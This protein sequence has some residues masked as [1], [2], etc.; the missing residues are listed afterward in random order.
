M[1]STNPAQTPA[2]PATT[3][4]K[5]AEKDKSKGSALEPFLYELRDNYISNPIL[6]NID[7]FKA[8]E[9]KVRIESQWIAAEPLDDTYIKTSSYSSFNLTTNTFTNENGFGIEHDTVML[10][11]YSPSGCMKAVVRMTT[12]GAIIELYQFGI[13]KIRKPVPPT[14]HLTPVRSPVLMT[15]GIIW[16]QDESRFMYMADD[17]IPLISVFKLKE[18]GLTR[19]KYR[20]SLGDKLSSHSNPTI[21][22]FDLDGMEVIRVHKP[23]E[24]AQKRIIYMQPAFADESGKSII[25]CSMN[26]VEVSDQSYFFNSPKDLQLI[27]ELEKDKAIA[28]PLGGKLWIVKPDPLTREGVK[29]EVAFFPK[30]SPDFKRISYMYCEKNPVA[31]LNSCGLRVLEI[32]GR[33][34]ET[35]VLD[36]SEDGPEFAGIN[37]GHTSLAKYNWIDNERVLFSSGHHQAMHVFEV[38][39]TDK[40]V[41]RTSTKT[42]YSPS[43]STYFL[44]TIAPGVF[45]GKRDTLYRNG[46]LY[47]AKRQED[48]SYEEY[49]LPNNGIESEGNYFEEQLVCDGIEATFYGKKS[50]SP[51]ETKPMILY[52]HGGPHNIWPNVFNPF[53]AFCVKYTHT[54]LNINYSGTPGRGTKFTEELIGKAGTIEIDQIYNFVQKMIADKKCDPAQIKVLSGSY[55]GLITLNLLKRYPDLLKAASLFNPVSNNF[56][57]WVGSTVKDWVQSEILGHKDIHRTFADK[58]SDEDAKIMKEKSPVFGDYKFSTELLL[59]T[60]SKD[61]VVPHHGCRYL[62]KKLRA[63]NLKVQLFEYP[64]EEH[65][66]M[67]I[68]PNFDYCIKT[69]LLFFGK[70]PFVLP[71][72]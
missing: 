60:G 33:K 39:I 2:D 42:V 65:L 40:K 11:R 45:V 32:E 7:C 6:F 37:G 41:K 22:I 55:G 30:P 8:E 20:D 23:T 69:A 68:G 12:E 14:T 47:V 61:D 13:L 56:S 19:F 44:S 1:A 59:F 70:F 29:E 63:L 10:Q 48:G 36:T 24:T 46:L 5:P 71:T 53:L 25:C 26:M 67:T 49:E 43:E 50:K 18:L 58:I 52:I 64:T 4:D 9:D 27:T 54:V 38:S 28:G 35:I 57:M 3:T 62:Y 15:D 51:L 21:F 66:I 34:T 31:A 72:L 16:S 17:P